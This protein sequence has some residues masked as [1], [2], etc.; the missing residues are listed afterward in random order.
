MAELNVLELLNNLSQEDIL[1]LLE[2]KKKA[3]D[4]EK[5]KDDLEM[6]KIDENIE[7]MKMKKKEILKKKKEKFNEKEKIK[8]FEELEKPKNEFKK[9]LSLKNKF[10]TNDIHEKLKEKSIDNEKEFYEMLYE[11]AV[12]KY[13]KNYYIYNDGWKI[14]DIEDIVRTF[15]KNI[16]LLYISSNTWQNSG[17]KIHKYQQYIYEMEKKPY[18]ADFK[19]WLKNKF[20]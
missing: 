14:M 2:M 9:D 4:V 18:I 5:S 15:I 7:Q 17:M 19:R 11:N 1:K 8:F 20:R 13:G 12:I 6:D 16:Q 3:N 10:N